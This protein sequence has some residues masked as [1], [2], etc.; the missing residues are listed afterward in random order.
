MESINVDEKNLIKTN[1]NQES[2]LELKFDELKDEDNFESTNEIQDSNI[3]LKI[4]EIRIDD[5]SPD[6]PWK[7]IHIKLLIFGIISMLIIICFFVSHLNRKYR[8]DKLES[9]IL[10]LESILSYNNISISKAKAE[11][12][13]SEEENS[14]LENKK[15]L[16][17]IEKIKY[18]T[19]NMENYLKINTEYI[20]KYH[21]MVLNSFLILLPLSDKSKKEENLNLFEKIIER[22]KKEHWLNHFIDIVNNDEN[23]KELKNQ[24]NL[25]EPNYD[26]ILKRKNENLLIDTLDQADYEEFNK[27]LYYFVKFLKKNKNFMY[28][29]LIETFKK[30]LIFFE[31]EDIREEAFDFCKNIIINYLKKA[32]NL[33]L[34]DI[35]FQKTNFQTDKMEKFLMINNSDAGFGIFYDGLYKF[36][37][38][39]NYTK[40]KNNTKYFDI[41]FNGKIMAY[42]FDGKLYILEEGKEDVK[43]VFGQNNRYINFKNIKFNKNAKF[44]V[45]Y[46]DEILLLIDVENKTLIKTIKNN[47]VK[48]VFSQVA[49][50]TDNKLFIATEKMI[51]IYTLNTGDLIKVIQFT[52]E[53]INFGNNDNIDIS[54]NNELVMIGFQKIIKIWNIESGKIVK[55]FDTLGEEINDTNR[56]YMHNKFTKYFFNGKYIIRVDKNFLKVFDSEN[57]EIVKNLFL[58]FIQNKIFIGENNQSLF[59]SGSDTNGNN[60]STRNFIN[61]YI[62]ILE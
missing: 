1:Q 19:S 44:L 20:D 3:E 6:I 24:M 61:K 5:L 11:E 22:V 47:N 56:E 34:K 7:K 30:S 49:L 43:V 14:K 32:Q 31:H 57:G 46:N 17:Q 10:K 48:D 21:F 23:Y 45:A 33:K 27:I 8:I 51:K 60:G 50:S 41:K 53:K 36:D 55:T 37:E 25:I 16:D 38:N 15:E 59:I 52:G 9:R 2:N 12:K 39:Q 29:E 26:E 28:K 4:N 54:E 62:N 35:K 58:D 40:M 18:S 42:G 13:S